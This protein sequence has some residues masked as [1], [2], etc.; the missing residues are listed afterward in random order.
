MTVYLDIADV[1]AVAREVLG[2]EPG[3][4]DIGLLDAAV[5]R[6]GTTIFGKDAY[7]G[8]AHKGA[9]LLHSLVANHALVDGNKRVGVVSTILFFRLNGYLV[10][11]SDDDSTT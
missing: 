10:T 6:P 9:A 3:V 2:A 5:A 11:A 7:P 1:L 8:L 4:R